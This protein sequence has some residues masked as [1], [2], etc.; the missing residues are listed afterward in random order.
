MHEEKTLI[1]SSA[2]FPPIGWFALLYNHKNCIIETQE[3]YSKQ[4]YRNRYS[5]L[6]A[7]KKLDLNVAVKKTNGNHTVIDDILVIF[8]ENI[9]RTHLTALESAYKSSPYFDFFF[10]DIK[11]FYTQKYNSL[12]EMNL[13]SVN[14]IGKILKYNFQFELNNKF[15]K[16]Y[17]LDSFIDLRF[18]ISPKN[19]QTEN[20]NY[21]EYYQ[22]FEHKFGF[23]QN[24]SILDLI[25]NTGLESLLYLKRFPVKEYINHITKK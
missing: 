24:L 25:F 19:L 1:L 12:L 11:N 15:V 7:N 13:E 5:I 8:D 9:I 23:V 3:T 4:T 18:D 21:P 16:E 22:T 6:S 17:N 2:L 10:D 14:L 20:F